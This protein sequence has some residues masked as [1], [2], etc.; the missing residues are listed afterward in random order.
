MQTNELYENDQLRRGFLVS[1]LAAAVVVAAPLSV[2]SEGSSSQEPPG[3]CEA[4]L[5]KQLKYK[6]GRC[7]RWKT[8]P[9]YQG[10]GY[11]LEMA[12]CASDH[13]TF[14]LSRRNGDGYW[15]IKMNDAGYFSTTQK[16]VTRNWVYNSRISNQVLLRS[17]DE[18]SDYQAWAFEP[19]GTDTYRLRAKLGALGKSQ[20]AQ[21]YDAGFSMDWCEGFI[22]GGAGTWEPVEVGANDHRRLGEVIDG[23]GDNCPDTF[24]L[25]PDQRCSGPCPRPECSAAG[26]DYCGAQGDYADSC[27]VH[28]DGGEYCHMDY[29]SSSCGESADNS[30]NA[31]IQECLRSVGS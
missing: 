18:S 11:K 7:M 5:V 10:W 26:E 6:D 12:D 16:C 19:L 28:W 17:C 30:W 25:D 22:Y 31:D 1:V 8:A 29:D 20:C 13:T 15:Q 21:P 24:D 14:V 27:F 9:W 4:E 2:R 23:D 3:Q